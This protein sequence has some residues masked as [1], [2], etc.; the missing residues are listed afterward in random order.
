MNYIIGLLSALLWGLS[1]AYNKS[2]LSV[3]SPVELGFYRYLISGVFFLV[4]I[5]G[6]G[7]KIRMARTD[8]IKLSGIA[9]VGITLYTWLALYALTFIS[10]SL[11]GVLNGT[12]PLLTMLGE[13][14]FRKKKQAYSVYFAIILSMAGIYIMSIGGQQDTQTALLGPLLVMLSLIMW[15]FMTFKNETYYQKYREID[16][17]CVQSLMG[18]LFMFPFVFIMGGTLADQISYFTDSKVLVDLMII[19]IAITGMGYLCYMYGVKHLGVGFMSFVMNLLPVVGLISSSIMLGEVIN[20]GS[21]LGVVLIVLSV[22]LAKQS[23]PKDKNFKKREKP[24]IIPH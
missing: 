5:Y 14:V 16:I 2:L 11:C 20:F 18:A 1:F 8:F 3:M 10:A 19:S 22:L 4:I 24:L 15:I 17:L 7:R 12:I 13:R 6:K 9:L 21:I 23:T